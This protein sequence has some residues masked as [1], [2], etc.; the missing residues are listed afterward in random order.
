MLLQ[1]GVG[2]RGGRDLGVVPKLCLDTGKGAVCPVAGTTT[3]GAL[4]KRNG[5]VQRPAIM[6]GPR[7]SKLLCTCLEPKP[8]LNPAPLFT[9][10]QPDYAHRGEMWRKPKTPPGEEDA[11]HSVP[12]PLL[13]TISHGP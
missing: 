6:G 2:S 11:G 1:K 5:Y 4:V 13:L 10:S 3:R 9:P 8:G 12:F 7:G